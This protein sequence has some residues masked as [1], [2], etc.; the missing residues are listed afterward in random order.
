MV[1]V[2]IIGGGTAGLTA[3]IFLQRSAMECLVIEA[4]E[5]GGR[6]FPTL[7]IDNYPGMPGISG[8]EFSE[9]L[10]GQASSLGAN[11]IAAS[12]ESIKL[13][14]DTWEVTAKDSI[15]TAKALIYA[16]GEK[17]RLLGVSGEIE[18]LGRGVATCAACDGAFFRKQTVA[19]VG[20]GDKA[21]DDAITLSRLCTRVHLIHRRDE[22]RAA[23]STVLKMQQTPNIQQHLNTNII[24]INGSSRVES[25]SLSNTK[26]EE[27]T[28]DVAGVFIAVGSI[29]QSTLCADFAQI[30]SEGYVIAGEDCKTSTPGFFVAGD[31]RRKPLRQLVTAAADGAVAATSAV[32]YIIHNK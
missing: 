7:A 21:L 25:V 19:I 24:S 15:Y 23:G 28:L 26:G 17:Q 12:V 32:E 9:V 4:E 27:T 30:D 18:L 2:I 22:F 14:K 11:L 10:R 1:D 29:P 20:G 13:N 8:Y 16:A 3:A 6:I 31:V 5:F